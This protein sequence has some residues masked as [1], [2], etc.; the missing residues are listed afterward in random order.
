MLL[1]NFI[2]IGVCCLIG[3]KSDC[4]KSTKLMVYGSQ[5][6]EG[7]GHKYGCDSTLGDCDCDDDADDYLITCKSVICNCYV[8]MCN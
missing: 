4:W 6:R 1:R 7:N 5:W 2:F 3:V 8:D